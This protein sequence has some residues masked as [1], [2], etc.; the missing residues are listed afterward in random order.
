MCYRFP[1]LVVHVVVII[2]GKCFIVFQ[3]KPCVTNPVSILY[4]SPMTD[5]KSHTSCRDNGKEKGNY[6]IIIGYILGYINLL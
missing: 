2:F 6:Y 1:I 5:N 3:S 4:I